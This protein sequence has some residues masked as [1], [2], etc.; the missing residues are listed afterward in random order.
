ME[1]TQQQ[2]NDINQALTYYMN[3]H[4]SIKNKKRYSD[5]Q[6]IIQTLTETYKH[7]NFS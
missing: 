5:F 3:R 6:K 4:I 2:L 7:E 1:F